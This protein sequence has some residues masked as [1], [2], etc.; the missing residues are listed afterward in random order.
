[1]E[2]NIDSVIGTQYLSDTLLHQYQYAYQCGKSTETA[3][4]KLG[5]EMEEIQGAFDS[6]RIDVFESAGREK[7]LDEETVNFI[8]RN[9]NIRAII[10]APLSSTTTQSPSNQPKNTHKEEFYPLFSDS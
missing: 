2:K 4:Q 3:L 1:M 10:F 5:M 6:T 7:R 8:R 9:L